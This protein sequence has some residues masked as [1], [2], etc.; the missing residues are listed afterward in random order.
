[1]NIGDKVRMV[2]AKEQG[3]VTRF[4][5]GNQ[6]EIE[7]ED[8][9]RIP[10]MRSEVVVVSPMEA[11]RLLKPVGNAAPMPPRGPII[12]AN[13]GI[14]MA[15]VAQNDREFAVYLVN[16][17][18]WDMPYT[19]SEERGSV[20]NG[21]QSGVLKPRSQAKLTDYYAFSTL[22]S[23]PTFLFQGL[24]FRAAKVGFR[25][26]LV[27][28]LKCRAQTFHASKKT[29]PVLNQPGHLFQLDADEKEAIPQA[30][31]QLPTVALLAEE[32]KTQMLKA[33]SEPA[34]P[35]S[36]ERPTAV[37]D[38][39]VEALLPGGP[40]SRQAGELL[41]LQ[42]ETFEKML[43]NAI[44]TGMSEITFIHGVG[45]GTLRTELHRRLGRHPHVKYFEDAQKQKFG[46]GATKVVIK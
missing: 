42:L 13:Q 39:H 35:L 40:G 32:I 31:P 7:I 30:A 37:V 41:D 28:R 20:I 19:L 45:S 24:W 22:D 43:E 33:K 21:L 6:V 5:T 36:F 34:T 17:T 38:L 1:M 44:A 16:N 14:Y 15:F 12:L 18:D 26:P 25:P 29:V 27:K 10:V 46:Y 2:R 8:G 11:E 9:F 3:V 4:L 23:W